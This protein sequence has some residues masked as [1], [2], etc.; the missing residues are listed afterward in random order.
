M[1]QPTWHS[2]FQTFS[3]FGLAI[4]TDWGITWERQCGREKGLIANRKCTYKSVH[5]I[6]CHNL[7]ATLPSGPSPCLAP[8]SRPTWP[9]PGRGNV[10]E[11]R[12]DCQ[13][14]VHLEISAQDNMS[15][16][17]CHSAFRT[18]SLFGPDLHTDLG[19]TWE[20][21]CEREETFECQQELHVAPF[22]T[23]FGHTWI[24]MLA[25]T[26]HVHKAQASWC[27]YCAGVQECK[28]GMD[29]AA[30]LPPVL[31]GCVSRAS[32]CSPQWLSTRP[33]PR[34]PPAAHIPPGSPP[35]TPPCP[36]HSSAPRRRRRL[37]PLASGL[38]CQPAPAPPPRPQSQKPKG[39]ASGTNKSIEREGGQGGGSGRGDSRRG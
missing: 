15:Q 19:S 37:W 21:Q 35:G 32:A 3:R 26:K 30:Y 8:T 34:S 18:F 27:G 11:E 28:S 17:T 14:E 31:P 39:V 24:N 20:R 7:P 1:S 22:D 5:R 2:H 36:R 23:S 38:R 16:P 29:G 4:L 6:T 33:P 13:Q 9:S 12:F 10:G 25:C